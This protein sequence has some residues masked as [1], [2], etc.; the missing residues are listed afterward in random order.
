MSCPR[1]FTVLSTAVTDPLVFTFHVINKDSPELVCWVYFPYGLDVSLDGVQETRACCLQSIQGLVGLESW[2]E[3]ENDLGVDEQ[4]N[5]PPTK[6]KG[7][8][9]RAKETN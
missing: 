8:F 5:P 1:G 6:K 2:N 9:K 7:V 4:A 3:E